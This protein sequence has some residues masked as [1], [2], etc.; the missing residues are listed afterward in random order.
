MFLVRTDH[1]LHGAPIPSLTSKLIAVLAKNPDT[2]EIVFTYQR[3]SDYEFVLNEPT[4]RSFEG[5]DVVLFLDYEIAEFFHRSLF[6]KETIR[7]Q[8]PR[9][10]IVLLPLFPFARSD[11]HEPES[12]SSCQLLLETL[13]E[14]ITLLIT[15]NFHNPE[16]LRFARSKVVNLL[17]SLPIVEYYQL[18]NPKTPIHRIV[19]ADDGAA[20]FAHQVGQ[21]SGRPVLVAEQ[22]RTGS[23]KSLRSLELI[24]E[25]QTVLLLDDITRSGQTLLNII[26][27][28]PKIMFHVYVT[29]SYLGSTRLKLSKL[30]NCVSF[31]CSNTIDREGTIDLTSLLIWQILTALPGSDDHVS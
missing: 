16:M 30:T 23:M 22:I 1:D 31:E 28:F 9:S 3:Y 26:E 11:K 6:L 20:N 27:A 5:K 8:K 2:E 29:H 4:H 17:E 14:G 18:Q 7:R 13:T 10:L 24:P 19:A 12:I 21:L 15:V 25:D